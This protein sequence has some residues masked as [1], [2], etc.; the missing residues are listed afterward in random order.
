MRSQGLLAST[1]H[2]SHG[3]SKKRQPFEPREDYFKDPDDWASPTYGMPE[4][5]HQCF[6]TRKDGNVLHYMTCIELN[7]RAW[8]EDDLVM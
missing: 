4:L 6:G 3:F 2:R 7:L 5:F 8:R 1:S